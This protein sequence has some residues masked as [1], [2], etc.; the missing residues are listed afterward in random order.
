[1]ALQVIGTGFGRTGTD[2]MR[3]ALNILGF[4][5]CHHMFEVIE[6]ERQVNLWRDLLDGAAPD[7]EALFEGFN[8]CVDWPSAFFWEELMSVYPDAKMLLTWREP[9]SWYASFAKTIA[10]YVETSEDQT[11]VG[12]KVVRKV[13]DGRH[14]DKDHVL[15]VY[16]ANIER[17]RAVVPPARL[18]IHELGAGWEP[19]CKGLGVA[20]PD[21]PYPSR[22]TTKEFNAR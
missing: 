15:K 11:R 7:W 4:G 19:L 22:N 21:V 17:V 14:L 10:N 6:S 16:N 20:V 2:S 13:F 9:E 8:S 3:E 1:M 12:V 18:V 5:L